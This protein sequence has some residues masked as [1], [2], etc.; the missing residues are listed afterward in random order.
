MVRGKSAGGLS[1]DALGGRRDCSELMASVR[2]GT[3]TGT[4]TGFGVWVS[5]GF[6]LI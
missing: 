6:W 5:G 2:W 4:G 3:G 1:M